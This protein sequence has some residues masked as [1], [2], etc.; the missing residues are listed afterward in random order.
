[1]NCHPI[2]ISIVHKPYHLIGEQISVILGVEVRFG[3]FGRVELKAF[4]DTLTKNVDGWVGFHDLV[5]GLEVEC[6]DTREP[7]TKCRVHVVG[8]ID[9]NE[10]TG[11]RRVNGDVVSCVV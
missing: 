10:T 2:H 4:T 3:G 9:G 8:Q 11:W 7:V 6:A 5:H 1:V